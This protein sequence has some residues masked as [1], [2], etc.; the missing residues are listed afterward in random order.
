MK[1]KIKVGENFEPFL[2]PR[3]LDHLHI[4]D[5]IYFKGRECNIILFRETKTEVE[6]VTNDP[7]DFIEYEEES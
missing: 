2:I 5:R 7:K 3:E 4:N 1:K 6:L